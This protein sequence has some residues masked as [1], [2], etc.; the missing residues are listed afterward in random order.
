MY[1]VDFTDPSVFNLPPTSPQSYRSLPPS[2][3][4]FLL[5]VPAAVSP[6]E[7]L[8]PISDSFPEGCY[9]SSSLL[10]IS[11]VPTPRVIQE[12]G[13]GEEVST[14]CLSGGN[15][16]CV[17]QGS[18]EP[19]PKGR[20]MIWEEFR[21]PPKFGCEL[22]GPKRPG[23]RRP[24]EERHSTSKADNASSRFLNHERYNESNTTLRSSVLPTN[25]QSTDKATS[26][27][28]HF[29]QNNDPQPTRPTHSPPVMRILLRQE[30][31]LPFPAAPMALQPTVP[32]IP[33]SFVSLRQ[34][35]TTLTHHQPPVFAPSSKR[36]C[37]KSISPSHSFHL[38]SP[39]EGPLCRSII[40]HRLQQDSPPSSDSPSTPSFSSFNS[41]E[42]PIS[43]PPVSSLKVDV[44]FFAKYYRV[45]HL[46]K[47]ARKL[48]TNTA[49]LEEIVRKSDLILSLA[50]ELLPAETEI[51]NQLKHIKNEFLLLRSRKIYIEAIMRKEDALRLG[52]SLSFFSIGDQTNTFDGF[53]LSVYQSLNSQ[54][55]TVKGADS[56]SAECFQL[57]EQIALTARIK[58]IDAIYP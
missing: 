13:D 56:G 32:A 27:F 54:Y 3:H 46:A 1:P 4:P 19:R 28:Q 35:P 47:L 33:A 45:L 6:F 15:D 12:S 21:T 38:R 37:L 18:N 20:G 8:S 24:D 44:D 7:A 17:S 23:F 42:S 39:F 11:P 41:L 2:P 25:T 36:T 55:E 48:D 40:Q 26:V 53:L 9:P 49:P 30:P 52:N 50:Q 31:S 43:P 10:K 14:E 16:H 51:G 57:M 34:L 58:Q 22:P 29:V 5:A